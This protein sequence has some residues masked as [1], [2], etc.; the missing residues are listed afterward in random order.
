[1][2]LIETQPIKICI[3]NEIFEFVKPYYFVNCNKFEIK[4]A[5]VK[6]GQLYWNINGV[7]FSYNKLKKWKL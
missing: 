6:G 1:M 5:I 7:Q 2:E 4:K 3:K